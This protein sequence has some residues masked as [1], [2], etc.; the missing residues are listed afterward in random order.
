MKNAYTFKQLTLSERVEIYALYREGKSLRE[1]G[2]RLKRDVGTICRELKR[3][4]SRYTKRYEPVKAEEISQRRQIKQRTK[5]PLKEVSVFLYVRE[6][7]RSG[8][9]PEIISG[10][11][12]ID[13]PELSICTETIYQYIY[14]KGKQY[15]L[16]RHLPKRHRR[17]RIKSGR[18]VQK[19]K[20][21][22]RIPGALS[23]DLR[24]K[25]A[26]LRKQAGHFE[27]DLMEGRRDTKTAVSVTVERKTRYT[28]LKKV[29]NKEAQTKEKVLTEQIK[30][31]QSLE[32]TTNPIV[33]SM[34]GDN[35]SENTC[36]KEIPVPFFFCHPY[37]SWEKGTVENRIGK[38]RQYIP[39]GTPVYML[40]D[41]QIQWVENTINNTP[42]KV[43]EFRTPNEALEEEVNK[44]KF[45]R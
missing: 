28:L 29:L 6:K 30:T 36:H 31:L 9:S 17:R 23:I 12:A 22:S 33:K 20:H 27:T 40:T 24:P 13:H 8:W 18:G 19:E 16:W 42:M 41:A 35:G 45:R 5:A 38:I 21:A 7:L 39:K 37:H 4:R 3:N 43:L 11:L 34:T 26:N 32:K 10:R 25:R 2:R 44:Y 15:K 1:I 14:G